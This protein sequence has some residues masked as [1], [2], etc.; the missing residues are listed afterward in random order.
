MTINVLIRFEARLSSHQRSSMISTYREPN[1]LAGS[2]SNAAAIRKR[3][4]SSRV[5]AG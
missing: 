3:M 1:D 4:L 5:T 2:S